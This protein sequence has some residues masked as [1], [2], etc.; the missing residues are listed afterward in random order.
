[1]N[2]GKIVDKFDSKLYVFD[3]GQ[4]CK[5]CVCYVI[6]GLTTVLV[7]QTRNSSFSFCF[8][9]VSEVIYLSSYQ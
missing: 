3:S 2:Y 8:M 9:L 4:C 1:M 5:M 6:I 7:K